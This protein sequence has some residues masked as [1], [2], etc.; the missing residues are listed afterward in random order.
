VRV[1]W[2][3]A[4]RPDL[5]TNEVELKHSL[6]FGKREIK[7]NGSL[8]Y[9]KKKMFTGDFQHKF[10]ASGHLLQISIKDDYEGYIYDL[11][12][13]GVPF[14]RL[15]R[16]TMETLEQMRTASDVSDVKK[17]SLSEFI[18]SD[19]KSSPQSRSNDF[20]DTLDNDSNDDDQETSQDLWNDFRKPTVTNMT[21][22]SSGTS[23]GWGEDPFGP[24]TMPLSP[25]PSST[26][27]AYAP[28][29]GSFPVDS[30]TSD[31]GNL[32]FN[33]SSDAQ[34]PF[35]QAPQPNPYASNPYDPKSFATSGHQHFE[36]RP[37]VP[38]FSADSSNTQ[39]SNAPAG[40]YHPQVPAPQPPVPQPQPTWQPPPPVYEQTYNPFN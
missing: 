37:R 1:T 16:I 6:V 3:F 26:T 2:K 13:D 30:L 14:H 12:V 31:F 28:T 32:D 17:M 39:Y 18:G 20:A 40:D 29:G 7:L 22:G 23:S 21:K 38:S 25:P 4:C 34:N 11:S 8:V 24:S 27:A 35:Y 9:H 5:K 19:S 36:E 33:S 10:H 15:T